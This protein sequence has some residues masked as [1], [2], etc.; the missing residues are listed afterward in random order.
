MQK[1]R[2]TPQQLNRFAKYINGVEGF[3]EV[4]DLINYLNYGPGPEETSELQNV[5]VFK[6]AVQGE[7]FS[8][9]VAQDA[10][11]LMPTVGVWGVPFSYA[12]D[13]L[14]IAG[15]IDFLG[16]GKATVI[17]IANI[18][19]LPHFLH[20]HRNWILKAWEG[21]MLKRLNFIIK[22]RDGICVETY[23]P[24]TYDFGRIQSEAQQM[25]EFL[26]EHESLINAQII[27]S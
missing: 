19:R 18:Y 5:E 7:K 15:K 20:D 10:R 22:T 1:F 12:V 24:H 14:T 26:I 6:Q 27:N 23:T 11:S 9:L 3:D 16:F 21:E 17:D 13:G 8:S 4:D 2:V 25:Y